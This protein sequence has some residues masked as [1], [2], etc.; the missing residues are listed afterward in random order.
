MS[1]AAEAVLLDVNE[2]NVVQAIAAAVR[3]MPA[4]GKDDRN[5][6][7]GFS[8][9]GI[10]RILSA[11]KPALANAGVV[12]VPVVV[13]QEVEQIPRGKQGNLWRL[14]TLTVRVEFWGPAGDH[15]AA[16][17][18]GEGFDNSD[19][20]SSKAHT[21]AYKTAL[22]QVLSI[23]DASADADATTTP[24]TDEHP[25]VDAADQ[26]TLDTLDATIAELGDPEKSTLKDWWKSAGL[27]GLS[28]GWL[29][30]PQV[31]RI[32]AEIA[33]VSPADG[34]DPLPGADLPLDP[35]EPQPEPPTAEHE[36]LS[37]GERCVA[38]SC[39]AAKRSGSDYCEEHTA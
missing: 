31:E 12:V 32:Q 25:P 16:Q 21:M 13:G 17:V 4:V 28:S 18:I 37:P 1:D 7:Q 10:E 11:A 8:Y 29:T 20:A 36:R 2:P 22:L 6:D 34:A 5:Q 39:Q 33:A 24:L 9:R 19:K 3:A 27:P 35:P 23:A 38:A 30:V 14:V 26:A 15:V